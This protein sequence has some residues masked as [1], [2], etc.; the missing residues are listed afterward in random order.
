MC[1]RGAGADGNGRER[2]LDG[3]EAGE[4]TERGNEGAVDGK[5]RGQ[6]LMAEAEDVKERAVSEQAAGC[7]DEEKGRDDMGAVERTKGRRVSACR[8]SVQSGASEERMVH[9][10]GR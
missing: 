3:R 7:C 8:V 6:E 4:A 1:R 5:E 10:A 2:R 9:R